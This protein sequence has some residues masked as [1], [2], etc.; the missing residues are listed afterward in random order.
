MLCFYDLK[1]WG[2]S[3]LEKKQPNPIG[4]FLSWVNV[5]FLASFFV[6]DGSSI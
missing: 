1:A 6:S 5:K 4:S 3:A 2:F